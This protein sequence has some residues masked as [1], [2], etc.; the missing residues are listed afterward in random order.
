MIKCHG[1]NCI[2]D[3]KKCFETLPDNLTVAG[4]PKNANIPTCPECGE[5]DFFGLG[6]K[7]DEAGISQQTA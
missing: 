5:M 4:L 3:P 2:Y 7:I 1:C 6:R